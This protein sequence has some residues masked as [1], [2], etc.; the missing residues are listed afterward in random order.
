[1]TMT[2]T[3]LDLSSLQ[4]DGD[5]LTLDDGRVLRLKI[6]PDEDASINDY[7]SDGRIELT[8]DDRDWS[9]SRTV[10]PADF[11][12]RSRI[13]MRDNGHSLWW[14]PYSE[15]TEDQIREEEPRIRE[16]VTYGFKGVILEL[17]EGTDFYGR[18]V[19]Q[20]VASLWGID[21]F[22]NGYLTEVVRELADE[23]GVE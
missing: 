12:G 8:R 10:R 22:A 1:M 9:P 17:C 5:T 16:L 14:E 6:M 15:L 3:T 7:E 19:V 13:I 23:L 20:N 4:D 21:S 11:S 18:Y 2:A